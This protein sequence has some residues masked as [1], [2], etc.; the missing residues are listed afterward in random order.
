[1]KC[2]SLL[3]R[4]SIAYLA[5]VICCLTLNLFAADEDAQQKK[6]VWKLDEIV[7]PTIAFSNATPV[8]VFEFL[9]S[10]SKRLDP[11]RQGV[12]IILE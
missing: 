8:D 6:L 7:I 12:R 9:S 1:M 11:E 10:E 3:A 2:C 4:K 5:I